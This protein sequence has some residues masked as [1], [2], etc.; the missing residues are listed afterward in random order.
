MEKRFDNIWPNFMTYRLYDDKPREMEYLDSI[1]YSK[2][3][4]YKV[5]NNIDE[6][7]DGVQVG[8]IVKSHTGA[9]SDNVFCVTEKKYCEYGE[10]VNIL[11]D[12][13]SKVDN[14]FPAIIFF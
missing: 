11:N 14:F 2:Y 1:G 13:Y 5:V 4:D 6:L 9:S 7:C 8:D 12:T 10:L 3:T